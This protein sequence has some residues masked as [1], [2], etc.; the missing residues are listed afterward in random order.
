M[1]CGVLDEVGY[2]NAV[3]EI[4]DRLAYR[5]TEAERE[6]LTRLRAKLMDA[7]KL[8]FEIAS[9]FVGAMG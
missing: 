9:E 8:A 7:Q 3:H 5:R 1:P 4:D 6:S 2:R